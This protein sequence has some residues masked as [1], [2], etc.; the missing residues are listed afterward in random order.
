MGEKQGFIPILN[1][2]GQSTS[3]TAAAW[4]GLHVEAGEFDLLSVYRWITC[5]DFFNFG[6]LSDHISNEPD[7][8][9]GFPDRRA[10][11]A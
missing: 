1:L 7:R 9:Y 11:H 6:A 10:F 5:Q 8:G 2:L 3:W 4:E